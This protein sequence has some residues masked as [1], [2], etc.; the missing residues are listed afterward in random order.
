MF[1]T[2]PFCKLDVLHLISIIINQS[3][4]RNLLCNNWESL[5]TLITYCVI[6]ERA[7]TRLLLTV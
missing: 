5:D 3:E 2:D 7:L 6:T 1:K 4:L